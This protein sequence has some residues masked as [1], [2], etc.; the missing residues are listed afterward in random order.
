MN[1]IEK[2]KEIFS[3]AIVIDALN[4]SN[5]E[6]KEVF[7]ALKLSGITAINATCA[8]WE[9][10]TGA[11][12]NILAWKHRFA[13]YGNF[14]YMVKTVDDIIKAKSE[15]KVGIILG[16]QNA[17]PI[18]DN[19][20]LISVFHSLGIRVIQLTYNER[21]LLGNGCYERVDDGLSHLGIAAVKEMN[22]AGI[23]IDL[24]HVGDKSSLEVIEISEKPV[25]ITHANAR[26]F[27]KMVRNKP[28]EVLD[29]LIEKGGV[30]GANAFPRFLANGWDSTLEDYINA[31]E[32]LIERVG[33][34]HVG[35]GTDFT[36]KQPQAFFDWL[37]APHG[38]SY[39]Q[40]PA[41]FPDP[42]LHPKGMETPDKFENIAYELYN[43][44]FNEEDINKIL[45][46]NW[47]RVFGEVW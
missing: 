30:I 42:T 28:D 5:W 39:R 41:P 37:F 34:D 14:L 2:S 7:D 17:F 19:L 38:R 4:V 11:I 23:L 9:D 27:L 44:G 12:N 6:N 36:H 26:S 3:K 16:W 43:R 15:N 25:A 35:I 13:K 20:D 29:A 46:L 24:S 45:G 21:N 22:Q 40:L 47:L 8:V 31:M 1:N 32:D 10:C 18:G 33:I